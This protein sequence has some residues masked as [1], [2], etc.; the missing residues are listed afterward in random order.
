MNDTTKVKF[1]TDG[2]PWVRHNMPCAVSWDQDKAVFDMNN[3]V[4]MPSWSAQEDGWMLVRAT[5]IR[6]WLIRQLSST[7]RLKTNE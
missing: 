5:G 3:N 6:A 7:S 2:G 1:I 4:F